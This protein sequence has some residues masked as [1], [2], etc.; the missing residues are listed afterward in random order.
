MR[1]FYSHIYVEDEWS[2]VL[3]RLRAKAGSVLGAQVYY[4]DQEIT[5]L[6]PDKTWKRFEKEY[7]QALENRFDESDQQYDDQQIS[8]VMIKVR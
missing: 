4:K 3:V 2:E 8:R 1:F 5:E 7:Q 6:I